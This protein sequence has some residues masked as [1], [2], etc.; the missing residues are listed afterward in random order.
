MQSAILR[1]D[2]GGGVVPLTRGIESKS[3]AWVGEP[4]VGCGGS[5][6]V[7]KAAERAATALISVGPVAPKIDGRDAADQVAAGTFAAPQDTKDE[8]TKGKEKTEKTKS[9]RKRKTKMTTTVEKG[10][11]WDNEVAGAP[12]AAVMA[13]VAFRLESTATAPAQPPA[14]DTPEASAAVDCVREDK[15]GAPVD[16]GRTAVVSSLSAA[17]PSPPESSRCPCC[18]TIN[19]VEAEYCNCCSSPLDGGAALDRVVQ[20][21]AADDIVVNA[22]DNA[23]GSRA[24][25]T[26]WDRTVHRSLVRELPVAGCPTG[27]SS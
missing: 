2:A 3:G 5:G 18:A 19:L 13:T 8:V 7:A 11:L 23:P 22:A 24:T 20:L 12:A 14:A 4:C 21:A 10:D 1:E 9:K 26:W 25:A 17:K 15:G 16:L 27:S 6:V